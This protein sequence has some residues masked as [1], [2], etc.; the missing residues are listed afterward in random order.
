MS[1]ID[2]PGRHHLDAI[3]SERWTASDWNRWTP[4]LQYAR[5]ASSESA[6]APR[7]H[8]AW[9]RHKGA[10]G[11]WTARTSLPHVPH[12]WHAPPAFCDGIH[13]PAVRDGEPLP[14]LAP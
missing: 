12:V 5:A 14:N 6:R 4:Q 2:L 11:R 3:T 13:R 7:T 10:H 8:I 9:G 1:K